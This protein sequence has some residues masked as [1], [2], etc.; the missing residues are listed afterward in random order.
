M[1]E[2]PE[3]PDKG[4]AAKIAEEVLKVRDKIQRDK[5]HLDGLTENLAAE[6][7]KHD[8]D[9]VDVEFGGEMKRLELDHVDEDRI[10]IKKAKAG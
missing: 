10:K 5:E 3:M 6:L 1:T 2:L 9:F 7:R 4:K 8:L